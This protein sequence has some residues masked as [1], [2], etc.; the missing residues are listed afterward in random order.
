M[1]FLTLAS[2]DEEVAMMFVIAGVIIACLSITT[3]TVR[4]L[5]IAREQELTK[6]EIAAYIAEGSMTPEQGERLITA[7]ADRV[8]RT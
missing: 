8:R 2:S 4:T 1:D 7:G 3:R 6:R 5:K